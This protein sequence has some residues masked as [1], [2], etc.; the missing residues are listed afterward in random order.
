[1]KKDGLKEFV[2]ED[3]VLMSYV[4]INIV[5]VYGGGV[6]INKMLVKVDIESKFVNG[7]RYIDEEIMEIVKMVFVGK[8]NKDLVNKIYIKGGKVVGFCGIDNN[9]IL[10]DLYK[11]YEFGFVGEIK[12][13]NVE[14][15]EFCLKLGYILVI[16][17]IGVGDDGEIY[18]INGDIV[19]FVIVKEL[20]VDKLIFFIDVFG[21]LRELDEEKLLII[22]V[23]LEDVDKLFEEGI[24]IGGMIFKIEGCVDVLN[25]GVNRVYILDGRVLYFIIIELFIDSGIGILIRKE[26][27]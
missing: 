16:V 22:E 13:V 2:M 14:F 3:F 19:V 23:I 6:E 12:K 15:I 18:N 1:M 8:V 11:N 25:N 5:L 17:I 27:E 26:N 7:F 24:I 21:L 10:C 20:N 9:M 4:G